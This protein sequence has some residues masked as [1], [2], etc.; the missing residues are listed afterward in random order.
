VN[1]RTLFFLSTVQL[2]YRVK[3]YKK[4]EVF[5]A[6]RDQLTGKL[7]VPNDLDVSTIGDRMLTGESELT[8]QLSQHKLPLSL[9]I[10]LQSLSSLTHLKAG[11]ACLQ[12]CQ[13]FP[14][15]MVQSGT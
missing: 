5:T 13:K 12:F 2:L 15:L 14:K 9:T 6:Q 4:D 8:G 3:S 10:I 7:Q 1:S 11:T